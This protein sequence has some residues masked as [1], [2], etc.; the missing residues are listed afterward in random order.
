MSSKF[1]LSNRLLSHRL[2]LLVGAIDSED[3][4]FE[5]SGITINFSD[6]YVKEIMLSSLKEIG[7]TGYDCK[8]P[9]NI[10]NIDGNHCI[11]INNIEDICNKL[12]NRLGENQSK[13]KF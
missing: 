8:T 6:F 2:A 1:I 3:T 9:L 5:P 12:F 10:C 7:L 13:I 11:C 4:L